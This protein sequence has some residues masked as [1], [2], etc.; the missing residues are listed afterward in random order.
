MITKR[1]LGL[2]FIAAGLVI[3]LGIAGVDFI[4]AGRSPEFGPTQR[5]GLGV[6]AAIILLGVTLLPLGQRPA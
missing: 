5:L 4:G 6:A 1:Q 2:G 3:G